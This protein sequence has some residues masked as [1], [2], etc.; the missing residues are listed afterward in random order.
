MYKRVWRPFIAPM[1]VLAETQPAACICKV[2]MGTFSSVGRARTARNIPFYFPLAS[3]CLGGGE[4]KNER[5]EGRKEECARN[6]AKRDIRRYLCRKIPIFVTSLIRRDANLTMLRAKEGR[7]GGS[8][9]SSGQPK[10]SFCGLS[11]ENFGRNSAER[12]SDKKCSFCLSAE[13]SCFCRKM[14]FRQK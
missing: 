5:K 13:R 8:V 6:P 3:F 2:H 12:L 7:K 4:G 9:F 10:G 11:A 1:S 14:F